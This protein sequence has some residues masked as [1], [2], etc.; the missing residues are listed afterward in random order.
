MSN[1]MIN[2]NTSRQ[3]EL[4]F[5]N[6]ITLDDFAMANSQDN[7]CLLIY[8]RQQLV[9]W[10][11][12]MGGDVT[13]FSLADGERYTLGEMV[14]RIPLRVSRSAAEGCSK[15]IGIQQGK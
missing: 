3:G 6:G 12:S 5:A 7:Q 2:R 4:Q 11:S 15:S 14:E 8:C 10:C 1:G 9:A 13:S